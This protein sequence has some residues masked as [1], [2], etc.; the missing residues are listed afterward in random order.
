MIHADGS[1]DGSK[2]ESKT[3]PTPSRVYD[4]EEIESNDLPTNTGDIPKDGG[5]PDLIDDKD[6]EKTRE[7]INDVQDE[8][9]STARRSNRNRGAVD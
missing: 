7:D 4:I 9:P 5:E 2:T 1:K 8:Q 6:F 3:T